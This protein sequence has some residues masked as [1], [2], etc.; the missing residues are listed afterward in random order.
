MK[1]TVSSLSRIE[2]QTESPAATEALGER[3]GSL[4]RPGDILCLSGNLGAGKTCLARGIA[5]GWGALET[6]SSPTFALINEYHLPDGSRLFHVDGYR[7]A[8]VDDAISTG[9][10]DAVLAGQIIV[11]E[12]PERVADL[13]PAD[14]LLIKLTDMGEASRHLTITSG[15]PQSQRLVDAL[16]GANS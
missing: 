14:N 5:R 15:G 6:A 4:L 10:E 9:L 7:L 3:I 16:A 13:L 8:N 2:L 12:W 11:I 1:K